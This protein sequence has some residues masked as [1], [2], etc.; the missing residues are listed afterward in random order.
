MQNCKIK[1]E[2]E[3]L[4]LGILTISPVSSSMGKKKILRKKKK[5][6]SHGLELAMFHSLVLKINAIDGKKWAKFVAM[7]RNSA[8][9]IYDLNTIKRA[10]ESYL[11]KIAQPFKAVQFYK[12]QKKKKKNRKRL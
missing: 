6:E 11:K 1:W 7:Q 9:L 5:I 8:T 3:F 4:Q 12:S 2:V 10:V